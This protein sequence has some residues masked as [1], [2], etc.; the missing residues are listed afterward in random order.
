AMSR[1]V[2]Y[3][4]RELG[5]RLAIGAKPRRVLGLVLYR[6][7]VLTVSGI[8]IGSVGAVCFTRALSHYLFGISPLDTPTYVGVAVVLTIVSLLAAYFPARRASRI[9]PVQC[10]KA[11]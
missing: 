6:G 10:L 3:R 5:I 8:G 11:E 9:D 2:A 7:V 1:Y 4:N